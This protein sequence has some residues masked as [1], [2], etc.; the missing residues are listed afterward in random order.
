LLNATECVDDGRC[1]ERAKSVKDSLRGELEQGNCESDWQVG[2]TECLC[3]NVEDM[4]FGKDR[5]D[6]R[7]A[8]VSVDARGEG[9][10]QVVSSVGEEVVECRRTT[11]AESLRICWECG[12]LCWD[13]R[14]KSAHNLFIG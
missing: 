13:W 6:D 9:P 4:L 5:V 10:S 7:L 11:E 8:R 3:V 14:K 12:P 2:D 1:S